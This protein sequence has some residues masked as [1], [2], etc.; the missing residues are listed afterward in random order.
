MLQQEL[1]KTLENLGRERT[2]LEMQLREQQ[3]ETEALR[4]QREEAQ[5]QADS[6]LYQVSSS[7]WE[8]LGIAACPGSYL[9]LFHFQEQGSGGFLKSVAPALLLVRRLPC[10]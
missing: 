7:A 8:S 3:T 1:E 5:A 4:A 9:L 6:A 2:E 10:S